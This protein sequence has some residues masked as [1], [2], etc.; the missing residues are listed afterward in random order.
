MR[1]KDVKAARE[2]W[3]FPV[4]PPRSICLYL[5]IC[6]GLLSPGFKSGFELSQ[7]P[8]QKGDTINHE[9]YIVPEVK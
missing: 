8:K 1:L 2:I 3:G 7:P 6:P 4:H 9:I 5:P